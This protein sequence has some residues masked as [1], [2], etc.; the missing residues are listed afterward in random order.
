MEYVN[1]DIETPIR[2]NCEMFKSAF[3]KSEYKTVIVN[4]SSRVSQLENVFREIIYDSS[5]KGIDVRY[6]FSLLF[7]L[8]QETLPLTICMDKFKN[9]M[10]DGRLVKECKFKELLGQIINEIPKN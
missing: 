5:S 1:P 2:I 10:V 4:D 6:K 7:S 9:V 3:S 8:I